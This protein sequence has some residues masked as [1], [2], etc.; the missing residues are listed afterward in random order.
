MWENYTGKRRSFYEEFHS[1]RYD[2]ANSECFDPEEET[3]EVPLTDEEVAEIQKG[4][5][6]ASTIMIGR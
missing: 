2:L 5:R 4:I 6:L 1:S 3:D